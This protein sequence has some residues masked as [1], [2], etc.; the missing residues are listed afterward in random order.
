MQHVIRAM[1]KILSAKDPLAGSMSEKESKDFLENKDLLIHM[2]T[3]DEKGDPIVTPTIYYFD[4]DLNKIYIT[5]Q[6]NSK[7]V[8][9]LRR[10][11]TIYFCID[12]PTPPYKGVRGKAKVK[13]NED[14]N[15]ILS[16][17][18]KLLM[19]AMGSLED[20]TAKWLLSET[21][22]GNEVILEISPS[23]YSTWDYTKT[24]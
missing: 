9:N 2:G 16:I 5:T 7:K 11:N 8:S 22:N 24:P 13:V 12:D 14:I 3:V 19:R 15:Y 6:K 21:E 1:V 20:P 4:R 23:Y 18:K 17:T 10:K